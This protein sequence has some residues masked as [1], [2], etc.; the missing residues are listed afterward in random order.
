MYFVYVS[1]YGV[2]NAIENYSLTDSISQKYQKLVAV[3]LT[4]TTCSLIKDKVY[5]ER[6][7]KVQ[8]PFPNKSLALFFLRDFIAMASA[9]TI[10]SILA[11]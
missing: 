8:Q 1:T 7:G 6:L 4:N 3:F 5:A 9:F 2:S 10:P 11:K